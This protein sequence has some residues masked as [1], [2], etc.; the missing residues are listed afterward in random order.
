MIG[1]S[2]HQWSSA[3]LAAARDFVAELVVRDPSYLPIFV[4]LD[5]EAELAAARE[6]HNPVAAARAL[7]KAQIATA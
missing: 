2:Q 6:S 3:S 5:E 7:A 1:K 4:R